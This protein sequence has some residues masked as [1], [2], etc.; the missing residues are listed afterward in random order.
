[1]GRSLSEP[2]GDDGGLFEL[3]AEP[4]VDDGVER[5]LVHAREHRIRDLGARKDV[6][7]NDLLPAL[8]GDLAL[9]ELEKGVV[10]V[11]LPDRV[12]EGLG[13]GQLLQQ[14]MVDFGN[15]ALDP[16]TVVVAV[17]EFL[18]AGAQ[19]EDRKQAVHD[20][21]MARCVAEEHVEF[22]MIFLQ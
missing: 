17:L 7:L 14:R 16:D 22:L 13:I 8:G 12:V 18:R 2:F 20:V 19:R 1:M 4:Q 6:L 11:D 10:L 5:A 3:D 21:V 9:E 15:L